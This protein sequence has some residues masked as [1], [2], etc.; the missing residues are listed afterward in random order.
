[1]CSCYFVCF[2]VLRVVTGFVWLSKFQNLF[3]CR[4]VLQHARASSCRSAGICN[5]RLRL[6]NLEPQRAIAPGQATVFYRGDEVLGGGWIV[7]NK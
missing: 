6:I 3:A 4:P 7:K 2:R 1:M 5:F